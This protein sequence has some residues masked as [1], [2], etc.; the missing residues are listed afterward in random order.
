[1]KLGI[2][3][4][5]GNPWKRDIE[6]THPQMVEIWYNAARPDDYN[7]IF[8]YL[9]DT[10]IEVGL[11]YWGALPNNILSNISYPDKHVNDSSIALIKATIDTAAAHGCVYVNMHTD[12]YSL[13]E[14][15]FG[16]MAIRVAS[17]TANRATSNAIFTK[18]VLELNAYA[19]AKNVILTVETVPIKD[20][21]NWRMDRDRTRSRDIHQMPLSVHLDLATHG[22]AIANDFVHTACNLITDD[23]AAIWQFLYQTSRRLAPKTRLIHL[24]FLLP[25]YN[26]VDCHDSLDN[27]DFDTD[28]AI[29]NKTEMIELLKLF[30]QRDDVWILVEP[31]S[32]H[33][34]NYFL[35]R[36]LLENAGVL[37]K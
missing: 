26:G 7:E 2:K 6:A 31:K 17:K 22:M 8:D 34:K 33:Q 1:M 12:L 10:P 27:P 36:G 21:P 19:A 32:D 25:P 24:G 20:P 3:I 4:A 16:S 9:S 30:R 18:R 5:P 23:R 35:A 15:N 11:H 29:P 37:T 13:L 28:A 14:V